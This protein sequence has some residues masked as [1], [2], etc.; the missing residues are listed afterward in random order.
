MRKAKQIQNREKLY[1]KREWEHWRRVRNR[2]GRALPY[3]DKWFS[4]WMGLRWKLRLFRLLEQLLGSP[5]ER[6]IEIN[7]SNGNKNDGATPK[8]KNH[9]S[10]LLLHTS[11]GRNT[12]VEKADFNRKGKGGLMRLL[13]PH[14]HYTWISLFSPFIYQLIKG[15]HEEAL[16]DG[17][18]ARN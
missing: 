9:G 12:S 17:A 16:K 6:I 11:S 13:L 10:A 1:I 7:C 5:H 3:S 2:R 18:A 8:I 4:I 14:I 15:A